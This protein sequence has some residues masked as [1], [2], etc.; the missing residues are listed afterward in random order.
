MGEVLVGSVD[1]Q[2]FAQPAH[3]LDLLEMA[4]PPARSGCSPGSYRGPALAAP[5][6][7][8][9]LLD[10]Q[11]RADA[12]AGVPRPPAAT[13]AGRSDSRPEPPFVAALVN[14]GSAVRGQT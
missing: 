14:P 6:L 4:R 9:A 10:R 5:L 13:R 12:L 2:L 7:H 11:A 3:L 1:V 8:A